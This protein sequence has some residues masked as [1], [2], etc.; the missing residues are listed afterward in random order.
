MVSWIVS[1]TTVLS[2]SG[3]SK[4]FGDF[5]ALSGISFELAVGEVVG[6]VGANG[7]GKSTLLKIVGG[8]QPPSSGIM[9]LY[10]REYRPSSP[11]HAKTSG[12]ASVFQELNLFLNMSVAENIFVDDGFRNRLGLIDWKA[13]REEAGRLLRSDGLDVAPD[14]PVSDLGIAQQQLVEIVRA[15]A[16]KPKILLLDE[17]TASLSEDQTAWLFA[18]VREAAAAG[19]SV[20]YV[21]HRLDEVS[22]LCDR[23]VILR[24]GR[25][26]ATLENTEIRKDQLIRHMVGREIVGNAKLRRAAAEGRIVFECV[27]LSVRGKLQNVSFQVRSGEILGIAGLVGAG[28]TEL[29]NVIYGI[30]RPTAGTL[31][32]EGDQ[33]V[34]KHPREAIAHGIAPVSEDRKKEGL[35]FGETV[36]CNLNASAVA[37]RPLLGF[38]DRGRERTR[39]AGIA[40][41]IALNARN[42]Q[43]PVER[44]SG[45]NQQ[46]VVFGR[47]LL[48]EADLLLLDEPTRGVDVGAREDIY[49]VIE[50]AAA[51][52][53][54]VILVSSDWEEIV[55]LADRTLVLRDG[56]I[57]GELV[58][59]QIN[60]SAMLH[61]CTEQKQQ[62][63]EEIQAQGWLRN[64]TRSLFSANNRLTVLSFLLA[65][66]FLIGSVISPF[67]L[68]RMNLSNLAWQSFVYLLLT[69]GQIA[70]IIC[71]GIDLS[72]SAAMTI[73]GVIGIKIY[74]A[75]PESVPL[76]L[77]AMLVAG[78]LIGLL[79]GFLV[80]RGRIN[81][82][83]ATLGVGIVLQGISLVL[84]P[85]P[86][87][88]APQILKTIANGTWLGIPI[89][90]LLGIAL[91]AVF[92][93][94]LRHTRFGRRLYAVGES[95]LKATWSGLPVGLTKFSSYLISA[96][97]ASLAAFYM[98]GRTGGA[99]PIV[100]PRLTLDSIAYCLIGGAT[101]AGGRGSLG[102]SLITILLMIMLLNVLGHSG[103]GI[104]YQQIV[105]AVLLLVIVIAYNQVERRQHKG[106]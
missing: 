58:G 25:L 30:L 76:C 52:G 34:I 77:A 49:S 48:T 40:G 47:A 80:V 45:G 83:I 28:R 42:L 21:S 93:V 44:L 59:E 4:S 46:K 92:F 90:V 14:S 94:V 87:A 53:K 33:L 65:T 39:A 13:M 51:L 2:F 68:N 54:G 31:L 72:V 106:G 7:A 5:Q 32:R 29:L 19:T 38:I 81:A 97:M 82:F 99:E 6:L 102:G 43:D 12:I 70:V 10:G 105:R 66:V 98:L 79:N 67:F 89:V 50:E 63:E 101:L 69:T 95:D 35:F 20:L 78:M 23:C 22:D 3:I 75:F 85:K 57:V 17:P 73:I 18:K 61:L 9:F 8:V 64:L 88:P 16:E 41:R 11:Q 1:T 74:S 24:D 55:K 37:N 60:E 96:V 84:T 36:T 86:I 71:G 62:R 27:G 103:V 104:F 56:Q 15:L 100:D 91:F 26:V